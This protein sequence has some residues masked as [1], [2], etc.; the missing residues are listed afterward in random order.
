MV[1]FIFVHKKNKVFSCNFFFMLNLTLLNFLLSLFLLFFKSALNVLRLGYFLFFFTEEAFLRQKIF[2]CKKFKFLNTETIFDMEVPCS[3]RRESEV[4]YS[5][6]ITSLSY[7]KTLFKG[8]VENSF[9][10]YCI[11]LIT[12]SVCT[13]LNIC[14]N[15]CCA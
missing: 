15:V 1:S 4:L 13:L 12:H 9:E 6:R 3:P 7:V 14:N 8:L 2:N 5:R 10:C 11:S